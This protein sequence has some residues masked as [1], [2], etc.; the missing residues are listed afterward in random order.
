[1][2]LGVNRDRLVTAQDIADVHD[3][4]KNHLM[5]IVYQLSV[6]EIIETVRGRN[7]GIRLKMESQSINIGEIIRSTESDFFMVECFDRINNKCVLTPTCKLRG[8]LHRATDAY[9]AILDS[10]TLDDLINDSRPPVKRVVTPQPIRI[11]RTPRK[12]TG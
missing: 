2:Y 12:K 3:I 8:L 5:K 10:A 7:G 4:S 9:L 6:A 1:M 11:H